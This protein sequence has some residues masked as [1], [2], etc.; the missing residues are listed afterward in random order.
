MPYP[1]IIPRPYPKR[2]S[3]HHTKLDIPW[4]SYPKPFIKFDGKWCFTASSD[5]T[6]R[7]KQ[8]V[9]IPNRCNDFI[10]IVK[11]IIFALFS[12]PLICFIQA[13]ELHYILTFLS[14]ALDYFSF[15]L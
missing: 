8:E 9:P 12:L 5:N 3:H 15:Y 4:N 11:I 10:G 13:F 2:F 6:R 1:L 7:I 14:E